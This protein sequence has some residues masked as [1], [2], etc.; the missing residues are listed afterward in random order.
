MQVE[1]NINST[2]LIKTVNK[3]R[4][5]FSLGI[6]A[7]SPMLPQSLSTQPILMIIAKSNHLQQRL[8]QGQFLEGSAEEPPSTAIRDAVSD[9]EKAHALKRDGVR[10]LVRDEGIHF[11]VGC[12]G[13][14]FLPL[15]ARPCV[16]SDAAACRD[17]QLENTPVGKA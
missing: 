8:W 13:H 5:E 16:P 3:T 15:V 1:A 9:D 17:H 4:H 6:Q 12:K 7:Q 14:V 2:A 10:E 11:R